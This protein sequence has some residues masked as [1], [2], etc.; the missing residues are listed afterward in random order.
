MN[1]KIL[2]TLALIAVLLQISMASSAWAV[3]AYIRPNIIE[4]KVKFMDNQINV[5]EDSIE[6][7]NKDDFPVVVELT[8]EDGLEDITYFPENSI[9]LQPNET[10][11]AY[12]LIFLPSAGGYTGIIRPTYRKQVGWS[13]P[14]GILYADIT[15]VASPNG[16]AQNNYPPS[17][18]SLESPLNGYNF[19]GSSITL[20]WEKPF[21]LDG[22]PILYYYRIDDNNDFSSP[23]HFG[24]TLNTNAELEVSFEPKTYYWNVIATDGLHNT[25]SSETWT[26]LAQTSSQ[27]VCGDAI[28]NGDENCSSC[29]QDCGPCHNSSNGNPSNGNS[30]SDLESRIEDLERE[31]ELLKSNITALWEDDRAK[32]DAINLIKSAVCYLFSFLGIENPFWS[33]GPPSSIACNASTECGTNGLVGSR[34]CMNGDV[35]QDYRAYACHNAGTEQSY[36]SSSDTPALQEECGSNECTD[37][38]CTQPAELG[39][40]I[41]R[42]SAEA[43]DYRYGTWIS[44]DIDGDGNMDGRKGRYKRTISKPCPDCVLTD[45]FGKCLIIHEGQPMMKIGETSSYCEYRK[46]DAIYPGA[47]TSPLPTEPYTSSNQEVYA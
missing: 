8:A 11:D 15:I 25:T 10:K 44:Y 40:V 33:C 16:S 5:V 21:D 2:L 39:E 27:P 14:N 6:L 12:F 43:G 4:I 9:V 42:T 20:E 45:Y 28:C 32:W 26:I 29:P 7:M 37:G 3:N 22:N 1:R 31:N 35:Y 17:V 18:F 34:Y 19:N 41:F 46:Y 36:C 47:E 24:Q 23:E 38:E 30:S 13:L